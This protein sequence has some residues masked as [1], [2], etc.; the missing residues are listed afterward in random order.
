MCVVGARL[1]S[2]EDE[3]YETGTARAERQSTKA[4][5]VKPSFLPATPDSL[6]QDLSNN[7]PHRFHWM[8]YLEYQY[9]C[10][11]VSYCAF[12]TSTKTRQLSVM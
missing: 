11:V 7:Q 2:Q 1:G 8:A 3:E 9:N 12:G 5:S 10:W 4:V 6:T